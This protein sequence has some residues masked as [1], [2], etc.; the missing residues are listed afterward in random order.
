[1]K[2]AIQL[3][4]AACVGALAAFAIP[5]NVLNSTISTAQELGVRVSS[6]SQEMGVLAISTAREAGGR[7]IS[8]AQEVGGRVSSTTHEVGVLVGST[9][10]EAVGRV[11][12]SAQ[13]V[14]ARVSEVR[15]ADLNPFRGVFDWEKDKMLAGRMLAQLGFHPS[16]LAFK[17]ASIPAVSFPVRTGIGISSTMQSQNDQNDRRMDDTRSYMNNPQGWRGARPR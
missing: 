3:T 15:L 2:S 8:T 5:M 4:V 9:A 1:M 12:S 14:G 6:T 11:S 13:T 7:A 10:R 17:P 16:A